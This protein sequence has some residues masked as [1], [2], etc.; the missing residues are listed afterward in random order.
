M[1]QE[2]PSF[3]IRPSMN[4]LACASTRCSRDG[5]SGSCSVAPWLRVSEE[6]SCAMA[7]P[8]WQGGGG[9]PAAKAEQSSGA[10]LTHRLASRSTACQESITWLQLR[11]PSHR[12]DLH[13]RLDSTGRLRKAHVQSSRTIFPLSLS[14]TLSLSSASVHYCQPKR[15]GHTDGRLHNSVQLHC[16]RDTTA[17]NRPPNLLALA[18]TLAS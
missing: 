10:R 16:R 15:N 12:L 1:R 3:P 14:L 13:Q 18:Q 2:Y 6:E 9:A 7:G 11:P 5:Q 17:S 8:L 4:E